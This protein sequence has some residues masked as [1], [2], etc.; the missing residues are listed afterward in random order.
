MLYN[1]GATCYPSPR[2]TG[3]ATPN[4][5][6]GALTRSLCRAKEKHVKLLLTRLLVV[7]NASVALDATHHR[8]PAHSLGCGKQRSCASERHVVAASGI[9]AAVMSEEST[10]PDLVE[11]MGRAFEAA[12]RRDLDAVA[13][14]FAE[15]ATF[16]GRGVGGPFEG[17]AA[18]RGMLEEWFDAYEELEFGF[19]EVR[20][21]GNGVVFAVVVQNG[22]P[23]GSAGHLRQR[24]GWVFVWVRGLI[25]R[26]TTSEVDEAH[27]AAERLAQERGR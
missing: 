18:I 25:A 20:D 24:E 26:L 11:L 17:R 15:D 7:L 4:Q 9:L 8:E 12:S 2:A 10:T 27:A 6:C 13:S 22:R 23:A 14:S 3:S 1:G 19:E 5:A 16:D 21:L